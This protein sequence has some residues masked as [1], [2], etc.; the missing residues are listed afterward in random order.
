MCEHQCVSNAVSTGSDCVP[1]V[2]R[3]LRRATSVPGSDGVPPSPARSRRA[4]GVRGAAAHVRAADRARGPPAVRLRHCGARR[5]AAP[6]RHARTLHLQ[7]VQTPV[8]RLGTA[9]ALFTRPQTSAARPSTVMLS[10]IRI[11]ICDRMHIAYVRFEPDSFRGYI[12]KS[13]LSCF[14]FNPVCYSV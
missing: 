9:A 5:P 14:N 2:P 12:L 1:A 7:Q 4:A 3:S 8:H 11:D 10:S 6:A 13:Q